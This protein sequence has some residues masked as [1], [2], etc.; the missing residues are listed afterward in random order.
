MLLWLARCGVVCGALCVLA[1]DILLGVYGLVCYRYVWLNISLWSGGDLRL[2]CIL[3][4]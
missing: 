4:V 1:L 2:L 3:V